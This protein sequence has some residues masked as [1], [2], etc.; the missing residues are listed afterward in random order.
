MV[1]TV[2]GAWSAKSV[3]LMVP[4]LVLRVAFMPPLYGER[5]GR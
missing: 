1:F 4:W 2:L 3:R 5:R